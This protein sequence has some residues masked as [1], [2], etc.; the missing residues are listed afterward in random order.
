MDWFE[1]FDEGA[2][3]GQFEID[4]GNNGVFIYR[5]GKWAD[6]LLGLH[7]QP[8][9]SGR[10]SASSWSASPTGGSSCNMSIVPRDVSTRAS[11]RTASCTCAC[12]PTFPRPAGA[13]RR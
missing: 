13:T 7:R 9:R 2:A 4:S 11:R 6:R 12:R 5:N 1:S 3:W 8:H 10:C